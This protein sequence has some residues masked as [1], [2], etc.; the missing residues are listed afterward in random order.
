[1]SEPCDLEA[2]V[3]GGEPA[4]TDEGWRGEILSLFGDF[5][6]KLWERLASMIGETA[7][8]AICR[9]AVV[10]AA[11][12][13][14]FLSDVEIG[15]AGIVLDRLREDPESPGRAELEGGLLVFVDAVMG[16]II[17]LTGNI[18]VRKVEPLVEQF[19]GR[20]GED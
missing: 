13:H 15:D 3:P 6:Q 9:S 2:R 16:L 11:R 5:F 4:Q 8:A 14:A 17:D 18:L 12:E 10:E 19:R 1:M 7:T 20:L